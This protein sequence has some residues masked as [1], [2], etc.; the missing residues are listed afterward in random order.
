MIIDTKIPPFSS[1]VNL[2]IG[3]MVSSGSLDPE[4]LTRSGDFVL[5]DGGTVRSHSLDRA[6]PDRTQKRGFL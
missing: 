2:N 5:P 4:R 6:T 3:E 1:N